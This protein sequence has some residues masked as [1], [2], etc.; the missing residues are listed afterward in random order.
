MSNQKL[1]NERAKLSDAQSRLSTRTNTMKGLFLARV[2]ALYAQLNSKMPLLAEPA[3]ESHRKLLKSLQDFEWEMTP[4]KDPTMKWLDKALDRSHALGIAQ[5]LE[6]FAQISTEEDEQLYAQVSDVFYM[7]I[8]QRKKGKKLNL[9]KYRL[10]L[11]LIESEL[12]R[13]IEGETPIVTVSGNS[14]LFDLS[15]RLNQH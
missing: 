14:L 9:T 3:A 15:A 11:Q 5:L 12:N 7:I 1:L 10:L 8:A 2:V 4:Y 13:E 6:T